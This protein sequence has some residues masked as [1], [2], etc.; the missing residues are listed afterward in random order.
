MSC[1]ET[2]LT[3]QDVRA[4]AQSLYPGRD[5]GSWMQRMRPRIAPFHELLPLVPPS[6]TVLDVGCGSGLFLGLLAASNRVGRGVGF[7]AS[8]PAIALARTMP[9][10]APLAFHHLD[11]GADWPDG[12]FDVVS[13]IDVLH[14]ISPAH[15]LD[16]TVRAWGKVRPGGLFIYKDMA[17]RPWWCAV[18]NRMHDLASAREW[19]HY[20][21]IE[22]VDATLTDRGAV[23]SM[24][25][26]IRMLWYQHEYRVYRKATLPI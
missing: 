3:V 18:M 11:V 5:I 24:R 15:Q 2:A 8:A 19:I 7:D 10:T 9:L 14:H 6:S 16:V 13:L 20:R 17:R 23:I 25:G 4:W 21:A 26:A 12:L 1:P 22:D